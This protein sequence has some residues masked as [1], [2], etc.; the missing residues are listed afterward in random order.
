MREPFLAQISYWEMNRTLLAARFMR[1]LQSSL[2]VTLGLLLVR[3]SSGVVSAEWKIPFNQSG[4]LK[5]ELV[6]GCLLESVA[7]PPCF[8]RG[9][10]RSSLN[11]PDCIS[12]L[13]LDI[14]SKLFTKL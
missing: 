14:C 4:N 11:T 12:L 1:I 3:A 7:F 8:T 5:S 9:D 2:C 10:E 13:G 6:P